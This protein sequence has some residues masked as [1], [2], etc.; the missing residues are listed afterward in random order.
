MAIRLFWGKKSPLFS[1]VIKLLSAAW[2]DSCS[3]PALHVGNCYSVLFFTAG[4]AQQHDPPGADQI[5]ATGVALVWNMVWWFLKEESKNHWSGKYS[6]APS[7]LC[8]I[9]SCDQLRG[10]SPDVD[11]LPSVVSLMFSMLHFFSP[12]SSAYF[13]Y[14]ERYELEKWI[15]TLV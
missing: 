7:F 14:L 9:R 13:S 1:E 4:F 12:F 5:T 2:W 8:L 3:P 11:A 15:Y 10:T 6:M